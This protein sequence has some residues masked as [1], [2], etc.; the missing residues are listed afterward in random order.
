MQWRGRRT[1]QNVED[2]R[3]RS[4]KGIAGGGIGTVILILVVMFMGGDP[5]AV[6]NNIQ[7]QNQQNSSYVQTAETDELAEFASV[8]LAETENV[9][10]ELLG[11]ENINYIKPKLVL[12]SGAVESACGTA[13]S[14][15]GPFYCPQDQS[16]Y[17][18]LSFFTELNERF[19]APG[20]FAMAYVIAHEIGHHVQNSLGTI[21]KVYSLQSRMSEKDFKRYLVRMELQADYYAGVWAHFAERINILDEGDI[22]EALNAAS[23]VG[24]DRI[25][26]IEYG[27][28]VP[29]S[30]THGTSEQ[31]KR[32]FNKGYVSGTIRGGNTFDVSDANL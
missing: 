6:I 26:K 1:S 32:W 30:F 5:T 7:V 18:D 21:E 19:H 8:V 3:G 22:E 13:G 28:V 9:W 24:D 4:I 29:D 14:S 10:T 27:R 25:Q 12:Y 17:I 31:R 11:K 16:V 2:R 20:D 23:A 15:T